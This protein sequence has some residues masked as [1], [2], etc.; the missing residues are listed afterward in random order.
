MKNEH[1]IPGSSKFA[2][3]NFFICRPQFSG[4]EI[5]EGFHVKLFLWF[6]HGKRFYNFLTLKIVFRE[7]FSGF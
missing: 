3:C 7:V 2:K 5:G 6:F 4:V 1:E